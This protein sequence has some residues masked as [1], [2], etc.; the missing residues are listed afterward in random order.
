VLALALLIISLVLLVLAA[1]SV[2]TPPRVSLGWLGLAF[3]AA[4]FLATALKLG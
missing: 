2:P 1:L 3:L 4:S